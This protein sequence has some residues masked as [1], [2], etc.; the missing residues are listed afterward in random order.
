MTAGAGVNIVHLDT[1]QVVHAQPPAE[2]RVLRQE[3]GT[4]YELV[5]IVQGREEPRLSVTQIIRRF[6]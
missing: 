3:L 5:Q 2:L 1:L 6:V 4:Y